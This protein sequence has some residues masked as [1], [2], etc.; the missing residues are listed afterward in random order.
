MSCWFLLYSKAT[1]AYIHIYSFS[2]I[3]FHPVL[4]QEPGYSSLC[5]TVEHH[6]L[7]ILNVIVWV[8][9]CLLSFSRAAPKAHGGS[10]AGGQIRATAAGL[11]H[12]HSN[13]GSKPHLWPTP[14][15]TATLDP[16]PTKGGRGSNLKPHGS[17]TTEPRQELLMYSFSIAVWQMTTESVV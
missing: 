3:N 14:Q 2:S 10:Q 4:Y 5:C 1:Q 15:P 9:F 6:C 11:H 13:V 16:Q 12:S 17:S 8:F 7:A